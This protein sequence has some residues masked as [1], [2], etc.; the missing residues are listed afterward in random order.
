M[1]DTMLAEEAQE[2]VD[3][4]LQRVVDHGTTIQETVDE[5]KSLGTNAA[6][7]KALGLSDQPVAG[8][9]F[10]SAVVRPK[11]LLHGTVVQA[12]ENGGV[13]VVEPGTPAVGPKAMVEELGVAFSAACQIFGVDYRKYCRPG[14]TV[15]AEIYTGQEKPGRITADKI[16]DPVVFLSR[17]REGLRRANGNRLQLGHVN[18][19]RKRKRTTPRCNHSVGQSAKQSVRKP[20]AKV[21]S[22]KKPRKAS[23][24][25]AGG[26]QRLKAAGLK[27]PPAPNGSNESPPSVQF[28]S[29][30]PTLVKKLLAENGLGCGP[31]GREP[32]RKLQWEKDGTANASGVPA[33][34]WKQEQPQLPPGC[35][36]KEC[37]SLSEAVMTILREEVIPHIESTSISFYNLDHRRRWVVTSPYWFAREHTNPRESC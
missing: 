8:D 9:L 33:S 34:R 11:L 22:K 26:S 14:E 3:V 20:A 31:S 37:A 15:L 10:F 19:D 18:P 24:S 5:L 17:L 35:I 27:N 36:S 1:T 6:L 2:Q 7:C 30:D 29:G 12:T 25:P 4:L 28:V 16:S 13:E 21:P 23:R 32:L